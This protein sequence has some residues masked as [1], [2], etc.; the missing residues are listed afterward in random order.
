MEQLPETSLKQIND[1]LQKRVGI[2][3]GETTEMRQRLGD[4]I[5][6]DI[7]QSARTLNVMSQVRKSIDGTLAHATNV[8]DGINRAADVEEALAKERAR[9]TSMDAARYGQSVWRRLLVSSPATSAVN[10][11]GF[12]QF[13]GAQSVADLISS[14]GL[15]M[16][17]VALMPFNRARGKEL[18][19]M[20][21]VYRGIQ[22]QKMRNLLDPYTTH[23][24]YMEF[25]GAN[26]DVE[27]ALFE[28]FAGGV[29]RAVAKFNIDPEAK[30]FRQTETI[31]EAMNNLTG[32][33]IQDSFT[34]SQIFM[35][36][37]EKNVQLNHKRTLMDILESGD[38]NL[39]DDSVMS[40]TLDTTLKSVFSKNYTTD[41]Q[42]LSMF[43]KQVESFSNLP[44][45]GTIL[46][47]GRFFNNVVAFTYQ[48]G[49][50]GLMTPIKGIIQGQA[51]SK[52][53]QIGLIEATSRA[54]V[55]T[56]ALVMAMQYDEERMEDNLGVYEVKGAG[57]TIIDA[58]NTFPFSLF[59]AAGRAANLTRR[60]ETVPPELLTELGT[61]VAVG[62]FASDVQFGNDLVNVFDALFNFEEGDRAATF[63]ALYKAGGNIAAGFT[64]PLDAVNK[65]AGYITNTDAAR[66]LRQARGG[67][68]FTQ[69][70]TRYVDNIFEAL[71]GRLESVTGEE[72]RVATR[73]GAL[74]DANPLARIF[75]VTVRPA[76]TATEQAYSMANMAE[77]TAS[78]RSKIPEYDRMFNELVAPQLEYRMEQLVRNPD[79][80]EG[81]SDT[82]RV[83]L[84]STLRA[85]RNQVRQYMLEHTADPEQRITA[86]RRKANMTGNRAIRAEAMRVLEEHGIDAGIN[87]MSLRELNYFMDV[88]D[89]LQDYYD[90]AR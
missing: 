33:R 7:N 47:F 24:A 31:T 82:R 19:R 15:T 70:S 13:Y 5:A 30:W 11:A 62:Q 89:Y 21:R 64:R 44:V 79:Y 32:V 46:P 26:K 35:T 87:D 17:G 2:T 84:Q 63:D 14:T 58:K 36:E 66:D 50:L 16:S 55:G 76:R 67:Q 10:L 4:L 38:L 74:R 22:A 27:K 6:K 43:A 60:G 1:R 23:D 57:G 88:V 69:A 68:L 40:Q 73:E 37:L 39:I 71:G 45:M 80:I 34:K 52:A 48:W 42:M 59:L 86:L 3:L 28:S 77:W 49:P 20:G 56:S 65:V 72:L 75:G 54:A 78:E 90:Q 51:K 18:M 8:I 53:G 83:M 25:L 41:D 29:D 9:M 12:T 81:N 61:Q 85:A